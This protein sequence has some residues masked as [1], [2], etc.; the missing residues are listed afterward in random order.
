M[1]E[2]NAECIKCFQCLALDITFP[3]YNSAD[4]LGTCMS[5]SVDYTCMLQAAET[6]FGKSFNLSF[7]L[8]LATIMPFFEDNIF[9]SN[10]VLVIAPNFE[11]Y[12]VIT[13]LN[14]FIAFG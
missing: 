10:V 9:Y 4:H 6:H 3:T 2:C 12:M 11:V 8:I 5:S 13:V 1:P 7:W 14:C